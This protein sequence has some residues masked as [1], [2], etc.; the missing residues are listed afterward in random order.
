MLT[1]LDAVVTVDTDRVVPHNFSIGHRQSVSWA[2]F[3]ACLA[4]N[5]FHL[6]LRVVAVSAANVAALKED[7]SSASW[8]IYQ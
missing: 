5:A 8:T 1:N 4:R 7:G 2:W 6:S 3:D